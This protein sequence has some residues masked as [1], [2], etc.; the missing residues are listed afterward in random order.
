MPDYHQQ[1]TRER[2]NRLLFANPARQALE[3]TLP[4]RVG[5]GCC[6]CCLDQH[7]AEFAP[8]FLGDPPRSMGFAAGVNPGSQ[9]RIPDQLLGSPKR[10]TSPIADKRIIAVISPIPGSCTR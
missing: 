9:S 7:P 5:T 10:V 2:H 1:L 4:I 8:P 3:L 6:L